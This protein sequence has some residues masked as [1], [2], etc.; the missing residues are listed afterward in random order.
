MSAC[1]RSTVSSPHVKQCDVDA[2]DEDDGVGGAFNLYRRWWYVNKVGL[3]CGRGFD[4]FVGGGCDDGGNRDELR[5]WL[6]Y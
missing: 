4:D 6:Q 5:M 1:Y 2:E 3:V